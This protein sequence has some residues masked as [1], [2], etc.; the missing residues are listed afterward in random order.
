MNEVVQNLN[1]AIK[2]AMLKPNKL[3]TEEITKK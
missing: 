3:L 2:M 1:N